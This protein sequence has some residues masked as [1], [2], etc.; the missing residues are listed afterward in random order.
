M[1]KFVEVVSVWMGVVLLSGILATV[2][3]LPVSILVWGMYYFVTEGGVPGVTFLHV[4]L[5]CWLLLFL[6]KVVSEYNDGIL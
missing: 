5:G 2:S 1:S 3:A 6:G 4:W